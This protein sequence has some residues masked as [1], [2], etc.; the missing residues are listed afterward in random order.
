[1]VG[2]NSDAIIKGK[3]VLQHDSEKGQKIEAKKP[4]S[5]TISKPLKTIDPTDSQGT[6]LR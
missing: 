2:G 4:N 1:M 3:Q 6:I 5:N